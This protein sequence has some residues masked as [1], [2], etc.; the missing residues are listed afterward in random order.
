MPNV[1]PLEIAIILLVAL[2][3][4]GSRRLPEIGRLLGKGIR[5]FKTPVIGSG[6][7]ARR[8]KIEHA[9]PSQLARDAVQDAHADS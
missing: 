7:E 4:F 2:F 5:E 9:S 1:G 6:E 8:P 3:L